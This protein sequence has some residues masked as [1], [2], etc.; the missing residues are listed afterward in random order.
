MCENIIIIGSG[1]A[2]STAAIYAARANLNPLVIHGRQPG[3]QLTTTTEVENFP[4]FKDGIDGFELVWT[5]QQQAERFGA[6]YVNKVIISLEAGV[7][8]K[9]HKLHL[10]GNETIEAKTI[11]VATGAS[12]RYLGLENEDRLRN[13]GV[14]GCATCDGAFFRDVPIAVV[15]GGDTAMEEALFL[16][17]FG[18]KV[19][20]IHRRD[21]FRASKV[22]VERVMKE[23]K[24]EI[25]WNSTVSDVFGEKSVEG[26]ELESTIDG[27]KKRVDCN[28]L[29]LA[30]GH[31]P[32][33]S[34]LKGIVDLDDA[35]YIKLKENGSSYT[36][37]T[38]IF[39]AGDCADHIYRQAI[40]A[41]GM[42]C[43]AA[44]DAERFLAEQE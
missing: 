19:Y 28:A 39:A 20:L 9:P 11:I 26:I 23:P 15:G 24:I 41:A 42:G 33:T 30:I 29:F 16:T 17:R 40:V 1:P 22:M 32:N 18:S 6:R 8:G 43:K 27:S 37:A 35:G 3:G 7:D 5:L 34:F 25:L 13:H 31:T 2:G 10:D 12:A 38:A 21:E 14:S 44:M 36:S 4:G